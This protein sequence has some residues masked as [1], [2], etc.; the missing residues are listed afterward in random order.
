VTQKNP[1]SNETVKHTEI[2]VASLLFGTRLV[3]GD[4]EVKSSKHSGLPRKVAKLRVK[5]ASRATGK[6]VGAVRFELTTSTSR[7]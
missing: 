4:R 1:S 5:T 3:A 7:T 6:M 2:P